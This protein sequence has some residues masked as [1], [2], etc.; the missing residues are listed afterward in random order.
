M[1]QP[2]QP[3]EAR[4]TESEAPKRRWIQLGIGF[5]LPI[6]L[7]A[8][9]VVASF[10]SFQVTYPKEIP[11]FLPEIWL[12]WFLGLPPLVNLCLIGYFAFRRQRDLAIGAAFSSGALLL[13]EILLM[14]RL[15]GLLSAGGS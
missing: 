8:A 3:P 5:G 10:I 7:M 4:L 12:F 11:L 13:F 6:L 2:F 15:S 14:L 9:I 1:P